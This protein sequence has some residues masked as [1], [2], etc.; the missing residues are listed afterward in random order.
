MQNHQVIIIGG[1]PGGYETAIRLNQ[2]GIDCAVVEAQRVGGVCLNQGCI[3]TKA[4]VKSAELWHEMQEASA[5]G[6]PTADLKLDYKNVVERKDKV[7]DQL[8]GGIEFLFRKRN[9]PIYNHK[10]TSINKEGDLWKVSL[11][12]ADAITAPYVIIATGSESRSLPGIKIDEVDVLSSTGM[13]Q[14]QELPASL[15]VIGGGVIGCEFA[16]IMNSFGVKVYIIEFLPRIVALEDEELSKRLGMALKKSGIKI[17]TG[18]GLTSINKTEAGLELTL[19]NDSTLTVDKV[20]MSVGRSP[21]MNIDWQQGAPDMERGAIVIDDYMH[22]SLDGVYAIGDV[23]NK[24]ALAHT[25]S[26]QGM[27]A[28]EHIHC[29]IL[30]KQCD[31]PALEYANIPRCT[32]TSL[33]LAS[34]GLSE[35]DAKERFGEIIVGKF[36]FTA[37]GKAL[38]M[39]N[40]NGLVK[41]IARADTQ[42][43]VGMHILGP[44]AAE[45]IAQGAIL[46]A[47]GAKAEAAETITFAH[48]TLSEAIKESIE[49]IRKLSIHK[50]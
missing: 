27:I 2:Y 7:V 10:A 33:E 15:A 13:L 3:P 21:V 1:G 26:K 14:M 45:L 41:T 35:A 8:V 42:E 29:R 9:I 40:A 38:A 23:T 16:S 50:I 22:S 28:A 43:L 46:I 39:G 44:N 31:I 49:D 5:F 30:G 11:A 19:S 34:V 36:P 37:S 17:S 32:F 47:Q 12:Q 20:L 25:A 6:L 48:P 18:V 4:L 24:L